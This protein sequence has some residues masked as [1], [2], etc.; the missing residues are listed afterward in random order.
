M[1]L[2]VIGYYQGE[3]LYTHSNQSILEQNRMVALAAWK[4]K[5]WK[6]HLKKNKLYFGGSTTK[7]Q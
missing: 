3:C 7:K 2:R 1:R 6:D 5:K 4:W